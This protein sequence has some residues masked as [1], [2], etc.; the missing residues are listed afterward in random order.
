MSGGG[1]VAT[2]PPDLPVER[3]L[4]SHGEILNMCKSEIQQLGRS[5]TVDNRRKEEV[6]A[7]WTARELIGKEEVLNYYNTSIKIAI[8]SETKKKLQGTKD[9]KN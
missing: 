2:L 6:H 1:K 5:E 4:I 8:I 9:T 7:T 3:I